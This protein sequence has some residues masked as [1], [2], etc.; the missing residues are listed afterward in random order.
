MQQ[1]EP[2][3][4]YIL[5]LVTCTLAA[6]LG[7][8]PALAQD[9]R[10]NILIVLFD[11]VGFTDFG[12]YGS[13]SRTPNIDALAR[14]GAMLSRYYTSPF[15][16]P[17]RAMLV[18]GMDN[19]QTG[20]GTLVETVKPE[21]RSS[22][23]YSMTWDRGQKTIGSLLSA[24]G[25]QT[26]VTGKWGIGE[27]GANLPSDFGFQRSYVMDATGGSNYDRRPY[28]PGYDK[29]S[30]FED[31]KP[32]ELPKDFYSSR[33]LVDKLI[34]YIDA[35]KDE[36]PFFAFLSLQAVHIPVQAPVDLID[37]Y[38]GTFDRGWDAMRAERHQRAIKLGLVPPTTTLAPVPDVHRKW[39]DLSADDRKRAARKMQVSA[40]MMESADQH[41]GRLLG[42]L[43]AAGELEN[44]I[45]IIT[46]DNGPESA[47]T[48]F[49]GLAGAVIGAVN[50][51]EGTDQSFANLGQPGS[52]SAIGPEWASVSAS[53]FNL[54]KFY[55]SEGG[56]RVP[57]VVAGPGIAARGVVG[58]PVHVTDLVP[59]LLDAAE[60]TYDPASFYGRSALPMLEGAST[61]TYGEDESFAFEV[62]GNAALYRGKWKITRNFPPRGDAQWRLYDISVDPGETTDLAAANQALFESMKAEYSAYAKRVGVVE[63]G[64]EDSAI[65]ELTNKLVSKALHKYW[66]Y[67]LGFVLALAATAYLLFRL[68]KL[69]VRRKPAAASA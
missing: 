37:A 20:M 4:R 27:T 54:Y 35:G 32:V 62:S 30:W 51:I 10:P 34:E 22:P 14:R 13:D 61:S 48:D 38:N 31:G 1:G 19:H 16:G 55:A 44:T 66:P 28:L 7:S 5:Q 6:S 12:A 24:A 63:L 21:L 42:H 46:S 49:A 56:L 65:K 9:A 57:M 11:D 40:G 64:P 39:D 45:V 3:V 33:S 59:T 2:P 26:Y 53:P 36:Q 8:A 52:L 23:G 17:S 67:L 68:V 41:I 18:T 58:A 47:D 69:A 29:V 60:V 25:Y 43:E 15:C 50:T